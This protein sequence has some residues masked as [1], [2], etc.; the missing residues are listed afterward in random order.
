MRRCLAIVPFLLATPAAAQVCEPPATCVPKAE[1]DIFVKLLQEK[2][3]QLNEGPE[4]ELDPIQIVID[5]NGRVFYS[6]ADPKP[7]TLRMKWC[8]YEVEA[9][10]K[11]NLVAAMRQPPIWGFRL[12]PKAYMGI[13]PT[14]VVYSSDDPREFRDFVD[15]G[16]MV[17]FLYYDWVNLNGAVGYRSVGA[18]VGIDLTENFG[19]YTGYAMTWGSWHHNANLSLSF[20][21]WNP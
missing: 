9:K 1:M 18:G 16:V 17:D 4:F 21:F 12:R 8:S 2:Q 5:R 10:G 14:E 13:I 6:G 3:C 20:S 15:A 7:Y 19:A 11:V